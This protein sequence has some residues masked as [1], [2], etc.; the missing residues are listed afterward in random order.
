MHRRPSLRERSPPWP[1]QADGGPRS[2]YTATCTVTCALSVIGCANAD[3]VLDG[4]LDE[5]E[6]QQAIVCSD[7]RRTEPY[8]RDEPRYDNEVRIASTPAGLIAAFT[9]DQPASERR[10]KPRGPRDGALTG[11]SVTLVV[12]FDANGQIGYEFSVGLSGSV[13]DGLVLNQNEFDKDWDGVWQHAVRETPEQWVVELQVPW[14]SVSM[15]ASQDEQRTIGVYANRYLFDRG[16]RFAC[17]A[18]DLDNTSFLTDLQ[19]INVT[20][21]QIDT[22]AFDVIPYSTAASDLVRDSTSWKAGAD[23]VWKPSSRL[24]LAAALN[25]DFGQVESDE[26]IVDFSAIETSFADKRPFFTEDQGIFDL[27]T[28]ARGQLVYTRRVGAAPDD[29]SAGSADIDAALKLTGSADSLVYGAFAAQESGYASGDGRLFAATRVAVP[30]ERVRFGHLATWTDRPQLERTALVNAVD[31]EITPNDWWRIA[32]QVIRSDIDSQFEGTAQRT[33]GYESWLRA[34]LNRSGPLSH[35]LTLLSIDDRFEM[36]DLGFLERNSLR[37]GEWETN[38]RVAAQEG[39]RVNGETQRLYLQY[40]ENAA[41]ERLASRVQLSRDVQYTSTWR[42]Y[43]ELR[44][45]PSQVDDLISRGN[46][47]VRFGTR[48]GAFVDFS[49]PRYGN[50]SYVFGGYLFQQGVKDYSGYLNLGAAWNPRD[51]LTLRLLLT[52]QWSDDWVLWEG[53]NLFGSYSERR[54]SFDFNLDWIPAPRHELRMRWQWIGIQAEPQR[55]LRSD[56]R[57]ELQPV[58][59]TLSPFTV[60]N[61]GMQLRYRYEI[62]PLSDLYFVYGRGGFSVMRDEEQGVGNLFGSMFDVRDADQLLLKIRYRM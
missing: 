17:P 43:Q 24:R 37:Q 26:L 23:L 49:T 15:R 53:G 59:E 3:I 35:T 50:W 9:V 48:L 51:N 20:R 28:P 8:A 18:I 61:L 55:A 45:I 30:L 31:A 56:A 21:P 14:S 38:R 5:A 52:P 1:T 10:V 2:R 47:P 29:G 11:D 34:D 33:H 54:L 58:A 6:W 19:R 36:D 44:Y 22:Q 57:G 46:G 39:S 60:S 12:D 27:R 25:P 32:G 7:W 62:G 41:G 4:V 40:R 42:S 16:E 13:R